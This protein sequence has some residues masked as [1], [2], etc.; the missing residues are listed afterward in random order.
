[1]AVPRSQSGRSEEKMTTNETGDRHRRSFLTGATSGVDIHARVS[2]AR[3]GA[4]TSGA[5]AGCPLVGDVLAVKKLTKQHHNNCSVVCG[6]G[7]GGHS[8]VLLLVS[9]HT[10]WELLNRLV[11]HHRGSTAGMA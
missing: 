6:G 11:P 2:S 1:M 8:M 5:G 3:A 4:V 7:H 9:N 10:V